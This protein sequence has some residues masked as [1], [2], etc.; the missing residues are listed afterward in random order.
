MKNKLGYLSGCCLLFFSSLLQA[1]SQWLFFDFLEFSSASQMYERTGYFV[2]KVT[3]PEAA[4]ASPIQTLA[5]V[6][7]YFVSD[8]SGEPES[9]EEVLS[10]EGGITEEVKTPQSADKPMGKASST[11][12]TPSV[13][14][15][16]LKE[17][18]IEAVRKL[19]ELAARQESKDK[20][21]KSKC[22]SVRARLDRSASI[23]HV[24]VSVT[25]EHKHKTVDI[26][27]GVLKPHAVGVNEEEVDYSSTQLLMMVVEF[28]EK[29]FTKEDDARKALKKLVKE[30]RKR[31]AGRFVDVFWGTSCEWQYKL[32]YNPAFH[33][34]A[35]QLYHPS[36]SI[37]LTPIQNY[38]LPQALIQGLY[39]LEVDFSELPSSVPDLM[40]PP[41]PIV[42]FET[43]AETDQSTSH[44]DHHETQFDLELEPGNS[45]EGGATANDPLHPVTSDQPV[46]STPPSTSHSS[47]PVTSSEPAPSPNSWQESRESVR[48]TRR[49]D[50]EEVALG[51]R[52]ITHGR[53]PWADNGDDPRI[54]RLV[55]A[56][57]DPQCDDRGFILRG[58][59]ER[60]CGNES[61]GTPE[62]R[63]RLAEDFWKAVQNKMPYVLWD[64]ELIQE[65]CKGSGSFTRYYK[66][67]EDEDDPPGAS[68][69]KPS[70][71][72]R[73]DLPSAYQ[74]WW[75]RN[76]SDS[77]AGQ[78]G[79]G[80]TR[81][82][83]AGSQYGFQVI[84]NNSLPG[85]KTVW[86][87]VYS[88]PSHTAVT[89]EGNWAGLPKSTH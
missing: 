20:K 37:L 75:P 5:D 4:S 24:H 28:L 6:D 70:G 25:Q 77:G 60:I 56:L 27:G 11:G 14:L 17:Q 73:K 69:P 80:S 36:S 19:L 8:S 34:V 79:G 53:A 41:Q 22:S 43:E 83:S 33:T 13:P 84:Q 52:G 18:D 26:K 55:T 10:T 63:K 48:R 32:H 82:A 71:R 7:A 44:V 30:W 47:S 46:V 58:L 76:P 61:L 49:D 86:P 1:Q 50:Y 78:G 54:H 15:G 23:S 31:S 45:Q 29:R 85:N 67:D 57:Q 35:F 40:V 72:S 65:T 64:K 81:S 39:N 21:A 68:G 87:G 2:V 66:D 42:S 9:I 3:L 16:K 74:D 12:A 88:Q 59:Y 89:V 51:P 38:D 62:E